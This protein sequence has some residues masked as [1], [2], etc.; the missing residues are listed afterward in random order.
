MASAGISAVAL[1]DYWQ[2]RT[3]IHTKLL[4][5]IDLESMERLEDRIKRE[6]V[7]EIVRG[8]LEREDG[9]VTL[10][11]AEQLPRELAA[12]PERDRLVQR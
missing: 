2:L 6:R 4:E 3:K 11:L 5:E 8:M 9:A 12:L 1:S 10:L 7:S